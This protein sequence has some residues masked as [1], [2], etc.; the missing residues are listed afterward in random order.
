MKRLFIL[1]F[2]LIQMPVVLAQ[3]VFEVL[4]EQVQGFAEVVP[5]RTLSFPLDHGK[6]PDFRIEWWY[7]TANLED[8]EGRQWGLQWTLFRQAL[9]PVPVIVGWDSNQV[10]MAHAALTMPDGHV[11]EQRFARG[12]IAQA[13]VSDLA[14]DG[15]F[16]A[17]IDDW[18]WRSAGDSIF[19]STLTFTVG[20][21]R[22]VMQL[23]SASD[24][25]LHGLSG[26][27]QKS[28]QGQ[29]SYYYSQPKIDIS[30]T[31]SDANGEVALSGVAWFDREWSSQAL[32][33]NQLGWDWFSLHID[34]GSKL[35]LYR[36]RQQDGAH[37]LSA[38]LIDESGEITHLKSKDIEL[39]ALSAS[40]IETAGAKPVSL[41]L[42]WRI[43]LPSLNR[44]WRVRALYDEQWMNTRFPYWE[45]V[46]IIED[47]SGKSRGRGYMELTGYD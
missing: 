23:S 31:V 17:W 11:H 14:D 21:R 5:G 47:S 12:G 26:Y 27:S 33:K 44:N 13:D 35:M 41:P 42:E 15:F 7:I 28:A 45:G 2:I 30:G 10:W 25:V 16:E 34:D 32:A 38:S 8:A 18:Q 46:V 43:N 20:Q 40:V 19:P 24:W 4:R 36:L 22:V 29:A 9:S 39:E 37:W 3:N 1:L 6:H